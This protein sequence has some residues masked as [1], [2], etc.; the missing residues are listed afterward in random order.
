LTNHITINGELPSLNKYINAE[1]SNRYIAAKIKR[2]ATQFVVD[3]LPDL[4]LT[5][6]HFF[7]FDWF[8][9]NKRKDPDNV[10]F[11]QKF[12][13]D[14]MVT[15]GMLDNDGFGQVAG[16]INFHHVDKEHPRVEI[17][18]I[19]VEHKDALQKFLEPLCL[20]IPD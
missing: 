11:T 4:K 10:E 18:F 7:L 1:R 14:G 19:E 16:S 12:L 6:S 8:H 15:K 9:K 20:S 2:E 5:G 3:N 17:R 13:L